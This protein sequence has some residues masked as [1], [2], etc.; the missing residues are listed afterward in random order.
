[1]RDTAAHVA[2]EQ[3]APPDRRRQPAPAARGVRPRHLPRPGAALLLA[4]RPRQQPQRRARLGARAAVPR[5]AR[6]RRRPRSGWSP[7]STRRSGASGQIWTGHWSDTRRPQAADRR[8]HAAPGRRARPARALRRRRRRRRSRRRAPRARH[9]ARLPHADRRDLRRRHA[10]RPRA[11][12]RRLPLLARHGLRRRR[13]D[14]RLLAD[15][16]GYSGAIAL[17][18]GL[19]AASGLWVFASPPPAPRAHDPQP[20]PPRHAPT[21]TPPPLAP[22]PCF[23]NALPATKPLLL[24]SPP[25]FS[26]ARF[27]AVGPS[28]PP[29]PPAAFGPLHTAAPRCVFARTRG[30]KPQVTRLTPLFTYPGSR[31]GVVDRTE[32][33]TADRG[34]EGTR[35]ETAAPRRPRR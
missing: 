9:R 28:S 12:R 10:R 32:D 24:P 13:P 5:R 25:A 33:E 3:R 31:T 1:M 20:P 2:L 26:C 8:R 22:P 29:P 23:R 17:V 27:R 21:G 6:R 4:G 34:V 16:L 35:R 11:H 18:A 14:R 7:A 19:T 15:A 30:R